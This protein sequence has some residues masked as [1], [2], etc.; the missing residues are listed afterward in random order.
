MRARQTTASNRIKTSHN[1]SQQR[2]TF[3]IR[4]RY[5]LLPPGP[6]ASELPHRYICC[7]FVSFLLY[8]RSSSPF[9]TRGPRFGEKAQSVSPIFQQPVDLTVRSSFHPYAWRFFALLVGDDSHWFTISIHVPSRRSRKTFLAVMI[10]Y[11]RQ[12]R[13]LL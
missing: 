3:T 6:G 5:Q 13:L 12:Y 2:I 7:S 4:Q 11:R 9:W 10:M 1:I 8:F